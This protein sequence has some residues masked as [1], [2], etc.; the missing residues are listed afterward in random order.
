MPFPSSMALRM[1][2]K[3]SSV[4]IISAASYN[5]IS[6]CHALIMSPYLCDIRPKLAHRD[7]NICFLQ[8]W[9]IVN[10]IASHGDDIATCLKSS[11][12]LKFVIRTR[13]GENCRCCDRLR[14]LLVRHLIN[15]LSSKY[16]MPKGG[17][18]NWHAQLLPNC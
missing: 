17:V 14:K 8:S 15:L 4:K 1:V 2:E 9:S 5:V 12:N 18:H 10:T 7:T 13:P 6:I 11:D 3:S 16:R